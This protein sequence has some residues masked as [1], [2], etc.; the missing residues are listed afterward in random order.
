MKLSCNIFGHDWMIKERS[1]VV[2]FDNMGEPL[3]LF[4]VKC[5]KCGESRQEWIDSY[6]S[7]GNDVVCKW[8]EEND[9]CPAPPKVEEKIK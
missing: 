1:N 8:K 3:R 5:S 2:Q 7:E 6:Y 9:F 4:I